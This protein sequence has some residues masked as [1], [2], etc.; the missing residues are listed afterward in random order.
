MLPEP[1]PDRGPDEE[2]DD[3]SPQPSFQDEEGD[4]PHGL[5]RFGMLVAM[6]D[7]ELLADPDRLRGRLAD[8]L[9]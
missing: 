9:G 1:F 7:A 3:S 6:S 8:N 2:P 4:R 5:P